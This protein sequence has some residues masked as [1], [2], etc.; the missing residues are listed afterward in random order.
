LPEHA[1]GAVRVP[2]SAIRGLSPQSSRPH[3]DRAEGLRRLDYLLDIC[4]K[5]DRDRVS[6]Q[7]VLVLIKL[8]AFGWT[9]L[10][11]RQ[12]ALAKLYYTLHDDRHRFCPGHRQEV[13][14]GHARLGDGRVA[15]A[16]RAARVR[17]A[18][19]RAISSTALADSRRARPRRP[20]LWTGRK[21]GHGTVPRVA[22]K[23]LIVAQAPTCRWA[24]LASGIGPRGFMRIGG[25]D[26]RIRT[27][28][29]GLAVRPKAS[30]PVPIQW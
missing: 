3:S 20:E 24:G 27:G 2:L 15:V 8:G 23:S 21:G 7:N 16:P 26:D 4:G 5:V 14:R 29:R 22:R 13:C 17:C 11:R 28:D 10:S 6:R 1:V 9:G 19:R 30:S 25:G 18:R 12:L